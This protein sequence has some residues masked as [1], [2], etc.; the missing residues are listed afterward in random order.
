MAQILIYEDDLAWVDLIK[1]A[2]P[3]D[4]DFDN[5]AS[6]EKATHLLQEKRYDL[7]IADLQLQDRDF[8]VLTQFNDISQLIFAIE[9]GKSKGG[10]RPPVIVVTI[11]SI[12]SDLPKLLNMLPGWIWG[13]HT[14][15]LDNFDQQ[16]FRDNV[17][18]ALQAR[19][20]MEQTVKDHQWSARE[21]L[22]IV[23]RMNLQDLGIVVGALAA[24]AAFAF[25]LGGLG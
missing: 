10:V 17:T 20:V 25:F 13:W 15:Y 24:I 16:A 23:L 8:T 7:I 6:I 12:G 11:H 14:K 9:Q 4:F 18:K 19:T 3:G 5:T 22:D 21:L 1:Q 2:L